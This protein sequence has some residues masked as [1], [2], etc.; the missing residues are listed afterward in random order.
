MPPT[1]SCASAASPSTSPTAKRPKN[2]RMLLAREVDHRARNALAVVQSIM[3]L[4]RG[5]QRRGL[6]RRRR[7]PHQSAGARACASVR[8][9]LAR[10]RP[11]VLAGGGIGAVSGRPKR[12]GRS[13]RAEHLVAAAYGAG[14]WRWRCTN[15][16]PMPP[17]TARCRPCSDKVSLNWQLRPELSRRGMDRNRRAPR[18]RRRPAQLRPEGDPRQHRT[19]ARRQGDVRMGSARAAMHVRDPARRT[20]QSAGLKTGAQAAATARASQDCSHR[21]VLLVEDEALVAMMIQ[22]CLTETGH[23]IVG[24]I[25][26]AADALETAKEIDYDA[27]ILDINLGDGM[28]YPVAEILRSAAFRSSSSPGTRLT[29]WTTASATSRSCRSRSSGRC[30]KTSS[31]AE[32]PRS[33]WSP[34]AARNR[35]WARAQVPRLSGGRSRADIGARSV[36]E[37][38]RQRRLGAQRASCFAAAAGSGLRDSRS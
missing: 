17:S 20:D 31:F 38:S 28:A 30:C 26:T 3:R 15:S 24:P 16:P 35:R 37:S 11:G 7:G 32:T 27:A 34:A 22:E 36:A 23:S 12:Q 13:H 8:C 29:R 1:A 10:R 4:T 18:W 19:A 33:S 21:R 9:A 25:S 5:Q 2:A 14:I 6:C